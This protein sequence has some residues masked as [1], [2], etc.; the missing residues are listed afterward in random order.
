MKAETI[1]GVF[2][3]AALFGCQTP[4]DRGAPKELLGVWE[5][6]S[7]R[8]EDCS[9]EFDD[10]SVIFENGSM[11]L[12]INRITKVEKST[13]HEKTLYH[14][15]Y[16]DNHGGEYKFSFYHLEG[17]DRPMI[18]FQ[19]QGEIAWLKREGQSE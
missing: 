5:A 11:H 9:F 6:S 4:Q 15:Y 10:K 3:I 16:K 18:R 13:E 14:I 7:P 19:H 2:F 12:T 17:L 1:M 8:Y